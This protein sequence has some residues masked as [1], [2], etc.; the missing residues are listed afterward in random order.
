MAWHYRGGSSP[1]PTDHVGYQ[2]AIQKLEELF[3]ELN[4]E[5]GE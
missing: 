3:P 2:S 4:E 5:Q 1:M